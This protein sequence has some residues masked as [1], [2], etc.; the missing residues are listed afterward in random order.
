MLLEGDGGRAAGPAH[1][2]VGLAA[3]L[4]A[5]QLPRVA[6]GEEV[7]ELLLVR[8]IAVKLSPHL[9]Q[10]SFV[11]LPLPVLRVVSVFPPMKAWKLVTRT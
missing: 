3:G 9:W 11:V 2:E 6:A 10:K 7:L 4:G 5:L 8:P 1:G